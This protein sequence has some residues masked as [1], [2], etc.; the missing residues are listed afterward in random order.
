MLWWRAKVNLIWLFL[1]TITIQTAQTCE[2]DESV[3]SRLLTPLQCA[4][5]ASNL[6]VRA[7]NDYKRK[8]LRCSIVKVGRENQYLTSSRVS[9]DVF[10]LNESTEEEGV[11]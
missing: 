10:I 7:I 8:R 6:A 2:L 3:G 9:D 5:R 11:L 4:I 1:V